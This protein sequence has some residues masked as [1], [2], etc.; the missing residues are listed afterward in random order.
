MNF[1]FFKNIDF[2]VLVTEYVQVASSS[3]WMGMDAWGMHMFTFKIISI[4]NNGAKQS[5]S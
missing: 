5:F 1:N 4:F 2:G 3:E